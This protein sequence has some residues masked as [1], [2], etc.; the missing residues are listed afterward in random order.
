M[1]VRERLFDLDLPLRLEQLGV[2][3]VDRGPITAMVESVLANEAE[4]AVVQTMAD[5]VLLP[6]IGNYLHYSDGPGFDPAYD[7]HPLGRGV[8]PLVALLATS[9]EVHAAHTARGIPD[10]LS[11]HSLADFGH[12]VAKGRWVDGATGLHNQG[13]LRNIWADGFLWLERL[14]FELS[15]IEL[16]STD[17]PEVKQK[18]VVINTHIP[19]AGPLSP[20]VVAR[21][22]ANAVGLFEQYYPEVGQLDWYWCHSWLLDPQI[23]DLAAGSNTQRFGQLWERLG[24]SV[25]DRD[26][27]YFG[28]NIE[29]PKGIE[30]PY[31]LDALPYDTR[32]HRGVIDLWRAGGHVHAEW[33]R[34]P[35]RAH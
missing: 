18:V 13:W 24:S 10:E 6:Q 3:D 1:D 27:Y 14:E 7:D 9:D 8:L 33:G 22:F 29:P 35:T 34:I 20:D 32:L 28:F 21:D 19:D 17:D 25:S 15:E 11:W 16:P 31:D 4:L 12:Q 5:T 2:H 30:L 23:F 26:G